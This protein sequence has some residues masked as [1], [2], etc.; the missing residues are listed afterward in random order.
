MVDDPP[1]RFCSNCGNP[2]TLSDSF[3]SKCGTNMAPHVVPQYP[4]KKRRSRAIGPI[5][6]AIVIVVALLVVLMNN[7][8]DL[9]NLD[10]GGGPFNT[11]HTYSA[12]NGSYTYKWNYSGDAYTLKFDLT[13]AKYLQYLNDPISRHMTYLN[14]RDLG[15]QYI[16]SNDSLIVY[17][18]T[19]MNNM[20]AQAGLDKIGMANM[21]LAFTQS[22]TYSY[23]N[24]S[25]GVEDYWSFPIQTLH[26]RTGDCEDKTFLYVSIM[27]SLNYDTAL[28]FFDDHMAA[29]L[30][31]TSAYG[32][33]YEVGNVR[34]F[35]C[36]TTS[37]GWE[38][39]EKPEDY[40]TSTVIVV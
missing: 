34:Y 19:Q 6:F 37:I 4:V 35:Y 10:N 32:T 11:S 24:V 23:D 7:N 18:S 13:N 2:L 3:C 39:G 16:T 31:C 17:I 27:E 22:I 29:G 15:L 33:Y 5:V 36:E 26:D 14:N 40:G 21:V 20:K 12:G 8:I 38:V 1:S 25:H 28:L 30:N 9:T